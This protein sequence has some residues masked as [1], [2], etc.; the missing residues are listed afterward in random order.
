MMLQNASFQDA[1]A[2]ARPELILIVSALALLVWGAF[3]S[4][5]PKGVFGAFT[6]AAM[7]ALVAAAIASAVGPTGRAFGGGLIV[8]SGAVFSKVV[9]YLASALAVPLGERWF[10]R[11]GMARF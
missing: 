2:L 11:R 4:R 5:A 1:V 3:Q 7:A 9:I 8:D 6:I 10:A